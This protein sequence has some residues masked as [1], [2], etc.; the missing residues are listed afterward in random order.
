MSQELI[1]PR[2]LDSSVALGAHDGSALTGLGYTFISTTDISSDATIGFT[3]FV[4][5]SYDA[6]A[7]VLNNVVPVTDAVFLWLRTSTD[8]GSTY[9]N[10][11]SDYM[12]GVHIGGSAANTHD[13]DTADSEVAITGATASA[14]YQVGSAAGENGV[15][16]VIYIHAPHLVEYTTV[17]WSVAVMNADSGVGHAVGGGVRLSAADVDAVQLLFS[18]GNLESGTV[19][20]YGLANA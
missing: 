10:S 13:Q 4:S 17:S 2:M 7:L 18:S 11:A 14:H 3:G 1:D 20:F 15:N 5:G 6:Y 9:D 12:W 8:G 16:G 19:N